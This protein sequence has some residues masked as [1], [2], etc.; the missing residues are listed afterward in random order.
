MTNFV[1]INFRTMAKFEKKNSLKLKISS[2]CF[3][4]KK[5]I[6]DGNDISYECVWIDKE[7]KPQKEIYSEN[8]LEFCNQPKRTKI[9]I[10]RIITPF[11]GK[12]SVDEEGFKS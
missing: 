1:L 8:S 12:Q 7:G 4:V 10:Q 11:I 5:V 3:E 6:I 2:T 9:P